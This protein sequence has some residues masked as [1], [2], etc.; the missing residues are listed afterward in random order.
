MLRGFV[1]AAVDEPT[2]LEELTAVTM[3][4]P[5]RHLITPGGFRMSVAMTNCGTLGWV[6]DRDG[7][8]YDHV[9]PDSGRAW[10]TMPPTF[11]RLAREAA[12]R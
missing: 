7:Y 10:P 11:R 4:A 9:D 6:S 2:L 8:R 12:A 5:F 3:A 1:P